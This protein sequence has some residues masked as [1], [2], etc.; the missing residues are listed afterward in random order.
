ME[1]DPIRTPATA[2]TPTSSPR[3]TC[4]C[5]TRVSGN[6]DGSEMVIAASEVPGRR[7]SPRPSQRRARNH[8]DSAPDAEQAA[9]RARERADDAS[10]S[11]RRVSMRAILEVMSGAATLVEALEPSAPTGTRGRCCST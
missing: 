2:G 8:H 7:A 4:S 10:V 3:G 1:L 9:E 6:G 11:V 5:R